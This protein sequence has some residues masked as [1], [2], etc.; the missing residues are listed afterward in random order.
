M[1]L[2]LLMLALVLFIHSLLLVF[3]IRK[4][5]QLT[6]EV[7]HL[8]RDIKHFTAQKRI[9]AD[10]RSVKERKNKARGSKNT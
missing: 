8:R 1:Y 6:N 2:L 9:S 7:E 3:T 5:S 4:N 10:R